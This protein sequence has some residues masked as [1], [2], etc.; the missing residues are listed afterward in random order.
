MDKITKQTLMD[1]ADCYRQ[2]S[3]NARWGTCVGCPRDFRGDAFPEFCE[4]TNRCDHQK[5]HTDLAEC[6]DRYMDAE[7]W[8][9]EEREKMQQ[10]NQARK[11]ENQAR[12]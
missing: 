4:F 12:K 10:E 11:Q 6:W 3:R 9:V 1:L 2:F 5:T 8:R 7:K